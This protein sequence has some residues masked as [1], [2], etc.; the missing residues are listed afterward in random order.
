MVVLLVLGLPEMLLPNFKQIQWNPNCLPCGFLTPQLC[1]H[2]TA[3]DP[4]K[5][6]SCLPIQTPLPLLKLAARVLDFLVLAL[7][8]IF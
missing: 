7:A 1:I 4:K 5:Q 2:I 3:F 8:T 6:N